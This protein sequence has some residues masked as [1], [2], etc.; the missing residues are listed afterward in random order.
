VDRVGHGRVAGVVVG[1]SLGQ[2]VADGLFRRL[3]PDPGTGEIPFVLIATRATTPE[4]VVARVKGLLQ[5]AD[6]TVDQTS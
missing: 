1:D 2:A 3:P 5:A 6:A 4:A